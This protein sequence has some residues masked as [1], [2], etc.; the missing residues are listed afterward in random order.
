MTDQSRTKRILTEFRLHRQ[1]TDTGRCQSL[2]EREI[3]ELIFL[4]APLPAILN[5]LCMMI[6]LRIGN[7]VSIMALL[8]E[9]QNHFCSIARTALQVG[10]DV[11]SV[12]GILS[13]E[14]ALVGTLEIYGC[15]RRR[16]T[17]RENQLIERAAD[18][19]TIAL[20]RHDAQGHFAERALKPRGRLGGPLEKPSFIN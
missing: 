1:C 7:V 3:W 2:G 15:D 8:D 14:H 13:R 11:F 20:E 16:P 9:D 5:K 6:D 19:A 10:L 12:S 4:G 17:A 18:L